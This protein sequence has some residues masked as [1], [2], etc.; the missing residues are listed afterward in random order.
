MTTQGIKALRRIQLGK[1]T[2]PG[3]AVAAT[4][5]WRGTGTIQDNLTTVFPAE[6]VGIL[7][8]TDRSY[9][10]KAEA[11][12]S[13]AETEATFEQLPYLFEAGIR[14]V[15]P[16]TDTPG[17]KYEYIIPVASTDSISS[18]DLQTFTVEGGDNAQAEEF[19][20]GFARTITI[21]GTAG[22]AVMMGAEIV[23]RQVGTSSFTTP[24]SIPTVEEILTSK[25]KLYIDA[26]DGTI[27]STQKSN[28]LLD[29]SLSIT[30]GWIPVYTADGN[31]YFSFAKPTAP[32]VMLSL[33]FE[34]ETSSIAEIAAW[35]AGTARQI[36]LKFDGTSSKYL[37]LDMAG[38]WDNFE[39]IG[40]RDGND[41]VT[42][43]FRCRYN[44][45][46]ALFFEAVVGNA[47]SALP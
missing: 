31:I 44:S 10:P 45:T 2:D 40:E 37:T 28:T 24:L 42:G 22:Q 26:A 39:A 20:Y 29:F 25:G 14:H 9:I 15:T 27:G 7:V 32:E 36:R 35:R 18:T 11:M 17:Y 16:S 34:H 13:L 6:D 19:A 5:I 33:T 3:T 41:I 46:A 8:G 4:A 47:L 12:I 21:S 1:E 38:K 30:T 23:G 43:N